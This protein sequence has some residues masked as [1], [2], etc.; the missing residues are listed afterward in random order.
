VLY[1]YN[2]KSIRQGSNSDGTV[3]YNADGKIPTAILIY[4]IE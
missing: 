4:V 1:N 3:L 2:G